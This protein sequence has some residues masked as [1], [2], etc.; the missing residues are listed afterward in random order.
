MVSIP[1]ADNN[2]VISTKF[3]RL[4]AR[5]LLPSLQ[6]SLIEII[7]LAT[8]FAVLFDKQTSSTLT[9]SVQTVQK[10]C[11]EFRP[12]QPAFLSDL[13]AAEDKYAA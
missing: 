13:W 7:V 2:L 6:Y 1:E 10:S 11:N 8:T 4:S 5:F 12:T 3:G 9:E